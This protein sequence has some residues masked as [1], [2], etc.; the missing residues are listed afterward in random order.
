MTTEPESTQ[1]VEPATFK[2]T[3]LQRS[4]SPIPGFEI[5]QTLA[6]IPEGV[7]SGRHCHPGGP[8][9]GYIVRGDVAMKFDDR[10]TITLRAGTRS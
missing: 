6:D 5:V 1:S 9:V 10:P 2:R 7:A 3:E 8:E 4:P